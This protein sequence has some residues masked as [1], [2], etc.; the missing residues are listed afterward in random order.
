MSNQR[1]SPLLAD[2][3]L[4]SQTLW[5]LEENLNKLEEFL[6][7]L[8]IVD[9]HLDVTWN[10]SYEV[11]TRLVHL[12]SVE[13]QDDVSL[14]C[15][16]Y[17]KNKS[18]QVQC[19]GINLHSWI[20]AV[21]AG[22]DYLEY[23]D[24]DTSVGLQKDYDYTQKIA[25]IDKFFP[26]PLCK[27]Q[28]CE[29]VLSIEE[30]A[31]SDQ[32]II[33]SEGACAQIN[34]AMNL[35]RNSRGL[36]VK[37]PS[38][39]YYTSVHVVAQNQQDKSLQV[40]GAYSAGLKFSHLEDPKKVGEQAAERAVA[41]LNPQTVKSGQYPIV[42]SSEISG[43]LIKALFGALS[44]TAQYKKA[45]FLLD[46]LGQQVLPSWCT[47]E[48][49]PLLADGFYSYPI[50][51]DALKAQ[52]LTL[53]DSGVIS[54]YILSIYSARRLNLTPN[55]LA[56]GAKNVSMTTN[57]Q[58]LKEVLGKFDR[59]LLI[60]EVLGTGIDLVNGDYSMGVGGFLVEK[61][62]KVFAL[63]N[64]TIASSLKQMLQGI[65]FH[66]QDFKKHKN[67]HLGALALESMKVSSQ[68]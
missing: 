23:I 56:G 37:I 64:T 59:C 13:F 11:Q 28:L 6:R 17:S 12:E 61:G 58:D 55:H 10:Q 50:C 7:S 26:Q 48:H 35:H 46:S 45:S 25:V 47:L 14:S 20:D 41:R 19:Y 15:V 1:T 43:H 29:H 38:S 44:G 33:N 4:S 52:N 51:Q 16:L 2:N 18:T 67:L 53:I 54:Q 22:R 39:Y 57:A 9:Y 62:E 31:L 60:D 8:D 36:N 3:F 30:H 34:Y 63:K 24:E 40:D 32:R 66:A 49:R 65:V 21:K 27:E 5:H 42:F 68:G